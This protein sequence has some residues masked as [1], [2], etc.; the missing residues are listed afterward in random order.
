MKFVKI[1]TIS[2]ITSA[3]VYQKEKTGRHQIWVQF[4]NWMGIRSNSNSKSRIWNG[5]H[6]LRNWNLIAI[7]VG[8][9]M[10]LLWKLHCPVGVWGVTK[11]QTISV[12]V[13]WKL[14]HTAQNT[15]VIYAVFSLVLGQRLRSWASIDPA[16]VNVSC[17]ENETDRSQ[18]LTVWGSAPNHEV[19]H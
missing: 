7:V 4:W 14:Q 11:T 3:T 9:G 12:A 17:Q 15:W 6:I 5:N 2:K 10:K 1:I 18:L 16:L 8:R 19:E 13:F